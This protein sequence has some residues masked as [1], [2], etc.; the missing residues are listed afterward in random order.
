MRT[1]GCEPIWKFQAAR[2]YVKSKNPAPSSSAVWCLISSYRIPKYPTVSHL[3]VARRLTRSPRFQCNRVMHIPI[4]S[5]P[6][7]DDLKR[8]STFSS[9]DR[10]RDQF[11]QAHLHNTDCGSFIGHT[12]NWAI[13]N[14][15]KWLGD[16]GLIHDPMT[17]SRKIRNSKTVRINV[18][19]DC[20]KFQP[21]RPSNKEDRQK[22]NC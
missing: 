13:S 7:G 12:L 9:E 5:S 11:S 4:K 15:A 22:Q 16:F 2:P 20:N 8:K 3:N 19:Y 14:G 10:T 17:E 6:S 18:Q 1:G 21:T